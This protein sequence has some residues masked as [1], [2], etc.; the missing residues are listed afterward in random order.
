[1]AGA[2]FSLLCWGIGMSD[3]DIE[4]WIDAACDDGWDPSKDG[5]GPSEFDDAESGPPLSATE[6]KNARE[7]LA[8]W[9]SPID[10]RR[11][12]H[13]LHKRCHA[14]EF[15]GPQRKF[16]LDAWTLAEFVRH[17]TV[18][19]V[20]LADPSEQWPDGYVKIAGKI[21]N[22]EA[23]I[24]VTPGR[25]MWDEYQFD[26]KLEFDPVDNWAERAKTIPGALEKAITDKIAKQY[27]SKMW[28]V[29][30][31]NINEGGIRQLET[32]SAIAEI[33]RRHAE[34]FDR[35]FVIWKDKLL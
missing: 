35:L 3:D 32:E 7:D 11:A 25:R 24:A 27:G 34:S 8:Q 19:K 30:Y 31:L 13:N 12:V 5:W 26:T 23:T 10:F 21:E 20:R 33:K 28:L 29:V 17:K 9:H 18:D 4:K 14:R 16:L 2:R 15:K 1:M 6:L 22:V